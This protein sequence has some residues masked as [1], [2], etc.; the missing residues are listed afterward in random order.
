MSCGVGFEYREALSDTR[1]DMLD[2]DFLRYCTPAEHPFCV[3]IADAVAATGAKTNEVYLSPAVVGAAANDIPGL[4]LRPVARASH[5]CKH[6]R[7]R[8]SHASLI[9]PSR[10]HSLAGH[11]MHGEGSEPQAHD[12]IPCFHR[13][14]A[15]GLA[16]VSIG[17]S[18]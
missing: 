4:H 2:A 11:I 13:R 7:N 16:D 18:L 15:P 6:D 17:L 8:P 14:T 10:I 5:P 9:L 3:K 1:E 12:R